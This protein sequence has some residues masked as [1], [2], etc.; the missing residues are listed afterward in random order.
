MKGKALVG[1]G[2]IMLLL[3]LSACGQEASIPDKLGWDVQDFQATNVDGQTVTLSD[4]KGKVWIADFNFT[5]CTTVCPPMAANMANLQE[6]LKE[7]DV[8]I[9]F[10]TFTVDPKRDKQKTRKE[11]IKSRGGNFSNWYFL[12]GYSF[13][14]IKD[15]SESSFKAALSKPSEGSDQ[16]Q[17][18]TSFFLVNQEGTI[19]KRYDGRSDVPADKI[20]KHIKILQEKGD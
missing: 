1:Y 6:K 14:D 17:H 12:G 7:D 11:F 5:N 8:P 9:Q 3:F 15:L 2:L 10:V 19:V 4:L 20:E 13:S 18:V 16:F